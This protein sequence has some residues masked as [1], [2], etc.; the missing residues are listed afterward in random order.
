MTNGSTLTESALTDVTSG[1]GTVTQG[2]YVVLNNNEKVLA[3]AD[4]FNGAAFFTTYTPTTTVTCSSGNGAA[5]L[6]SVNLSTGDA[7]LN[8][9]DGTAATPG[10][11]ALSLA[12]TI[13]TGIPSRPDVTLSGSGRTGNPYVIT[14]TTDRQISNTPLPPITTKKLL[15]WREVF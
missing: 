12:K 14:G 9:A 4:V 3:A 7:A 13:G 5:K 8:L 1:S 11:S 6:Y 10:Q 15:A 2:W